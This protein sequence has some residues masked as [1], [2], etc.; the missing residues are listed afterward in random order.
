MVGPKGDITTPDVIVDRLF[1]GREIRPVGLLTHECWQQ[2]GSKEIA[3]AGYGLMALGGGA[4]IAPLL[5]V[6]NGTVVIARKSWRL[7]N[8]GDHV[9]EV[10]LNGNALATIGLPADEI[11]AAGGDGDALPRGY[12]LVRTIEGDTRTAKLEDP[13][14][15]RSLEHR[16]VFEDAAKDRWGKKRPRPRY[17]IGPTQKDIPHYI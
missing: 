7:A 11:S 3:V 6:G 16:I 2:A 4:L 17:S 1:V 14:Q 5:V 9:G 10:T 8:L 13:E 15:G 12:L